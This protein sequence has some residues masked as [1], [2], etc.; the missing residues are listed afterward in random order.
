MGNLRKSV[1]NLANAVSVNKQS[2]INLY[3]QLSRV[4]Q[5]TNRR[6]NAITQLGSIVNENINKI[7]YNMNVLRTEFEKDYNDIQLRLTSLNRFKGFIAGQNNIAS[8]L[9]SKI[10]C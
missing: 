3:T 9:F 10:Y 6:L 1:T 2:I 4:M 7:I 8:Y 5:L